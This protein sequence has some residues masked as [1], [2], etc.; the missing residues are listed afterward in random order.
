MWVSSPSSWSWRPGP[1]HL[2]I[3]ARPQKARA[4]CEAAARPREDVPVDHHC[5]RFRV[6]SAEGHGAAHDRVEAAVHPEEQ[7]SEL[8]GGVRVAEHLRGVVVIRDDVNVKVRPLVGVAAPGRSDQHD[9]RDSSV[10]GEAVYGCFE[11]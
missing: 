4:S 10:L 7:V 5:A 2:D 8:F 3:V 6:V 1:V 9:C 11:E